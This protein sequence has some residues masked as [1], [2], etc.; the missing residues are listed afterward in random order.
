MPRCRGLH[1]AG[2]SSSILRLRRMVPRCLFASLLLV[3]LQ[4]RFRLGRR[5]E[6][7]VTDRR[8]Q[9]TRTEAVQTRRARCALRCCAQR[10]AGEVQ[11]RTELYSSRRVRWTAGAAR[12]GA[13][14]HRVGTPP[15]HRDR[16]ATCTNQSH[17][18][19]DSHSLAARSPA[20]FRASCA[21]TTT[22]PLSNQPLQHDSFSRGERSCL[23]NT[24]SSTLLRCSCPSAFRRRP[25]PP[26]RRSGVWQ[27]LV[28]GA[29]GMVWP[30]DALWASPRQNH[31]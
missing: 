15:L 24:S 23:A 2:C 30:P 11:L 27:R 19:A 17:I 21:L 9:T 16:S 8:G 20:T 26:R 7:R 10:C 14:H 28:A 13:V 22:K 6:D 18:R 4:L 31:H 12:R 3:L 29:E 5:R 25:P 1:R